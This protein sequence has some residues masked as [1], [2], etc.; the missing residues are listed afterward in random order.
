MHATTTADA[1]TRAELH[2][3]RAHRFG[4]RLLRQ[5]IAQLIAIGVAHALIEDVNEPLY[6]IDGMLWQLKK[7]GKLVGS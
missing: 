3:Q 6:R 7:A 5:S 1:R 4:K 2:R